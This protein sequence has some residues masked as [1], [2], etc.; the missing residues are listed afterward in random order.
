MN[1]LKRLVLVL[2][3]A[4]L[5][6][7]PVKSQTPA[8]EA[9]KKDYPNLFDMYGMESLEKQKAHFIFAIDGSSCMAT[10]LVTIKPL[11]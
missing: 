9:V 3:L 6:I 4:L 7:S 8:H 11:I 5:A 1:N 2:A 10:N